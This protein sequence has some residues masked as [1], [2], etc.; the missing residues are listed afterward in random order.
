MA[1][2]KGKCKEREGVLTP[3]DTTVVSKGDKSKED[4]EKVLTV[5]SGVK[6]KQQKRKK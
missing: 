6:K 5:L 4:M 2:K 1:S 3:S